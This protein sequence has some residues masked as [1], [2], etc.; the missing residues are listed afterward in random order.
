M[1]RFG[2]LR[3]A[4]SNDDGW[5]SAEEWDRRLGITGHTADSAH[6]EYKSNLGKIR[7]AISEGLDPY[8]FQARLRS[9]G[10]QPHYEP[11]QETPEAIAHAEAVLASLR[12]QWNTSDK[13]GTS[14]PKAKKGRRNTVE[15]AG[16]NAGRNTGGNSRRVRTVRPSKHEGR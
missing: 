5:T 7:R 15:S 6:S 16:R 14:G 12:A 10:Y 3:V 13:G 4:R 11:K 1:K 9:Y 2:S 8:D